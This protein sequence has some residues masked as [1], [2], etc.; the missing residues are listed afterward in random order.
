[1]NKDKLKK[2]Y[3]R[4]IGKITQKKLKF[5]NFT[6]ISNNCF[7]GIFYRNNALEYLSPTCG[8]FFIG[9]E[10]IKFIYNLRHY[11][12][13]DEINEIQ[14]DESQY[15]DY[16]KKIQLR[17]LLFYEMFGCLYFYSFFLIFILII[18]LFIIF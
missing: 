15:S 1:M 4:Y 6:I 10:Y 7:G 12:E 18:F 13:I 3:Y 17:E 14:I 8:L 2:I 9:K 16:L 11:L 5:T